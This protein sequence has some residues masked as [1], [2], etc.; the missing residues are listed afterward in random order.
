LKDFD[1]F[2]RTFVGF[3]IDVP[4]FDAFRIQ[5]QVEN[6]NVQLQQT[7]LEYKR[8]EQTVRTQL[9]TGLLNLNAA[10]KQIDITDRSLKSAEQNYL[11]A[12]ERFE[13]GTSGIIEYQTANTQFVT[14]KINRINAVYNYIDAQYQ[15]KFAMGNL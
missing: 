12:K 1:V 9:Q 15:I 3:S 11:S 13:V 4:I 10:E 7:E 6:S 14:A 2:S 8:I 5:Q